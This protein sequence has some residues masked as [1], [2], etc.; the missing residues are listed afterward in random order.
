MKPY[1][2]RKACQKKLVAVHEVFEIPNLN[3]QIP[4]KSQ[5]PDTNN[6]SQFVI[7]NFG[8]WNLFAIWDLLFVILTN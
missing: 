8:H 7:L 4:N 1:Q 2:S 6:K 5:I 3:E